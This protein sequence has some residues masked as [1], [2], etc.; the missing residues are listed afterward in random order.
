MATPESTPGMRLK[1]LKTAVSRR[2]SSLNATLEA[3]D[4]R[5]QL[6]EQFEKDNGYSYD[7]VF[8][9]KVHDENAELTQLQKEFSM[10]T[11]LQRLAR[12]R[13]RDQDVLL[14]RPP[15]SCFAS[16]APRSSGS[17]RRRIVLT[18]RSSSIRSRRAASRRQGYPEQ[19]IAPIQIHDEKGIS[20]R[21]PYQNLFAK[22]DM[23]PRLQPAYKKFGHKEDP[24]R[25]VRP[26]Q[27]HPQHHQ[28]ASDRTRGCALNLEILEKNKCLVASFPLHEYE[29]LS[30]LKPSGSTGAPRHGRSRSTTSRTTLAR[31]SG[32]TLHGSGITRRG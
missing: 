3:K 2:G 12:G 32:S 8:V 17:A 26:H 15:S 9:F 6:D 28:V 20:S 23:E 14:G 5:L 22:Y 25:G 4:V 19:N 13:H 18:T 27:A 30:A 24:F 21:D 31:K 10:R 7:Y 16:C 1:A 11:I 29:E